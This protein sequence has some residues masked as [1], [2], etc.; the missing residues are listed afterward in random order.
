[1]TL[2]LSSLITRSLPFIVVF[3]LGILV[4][5]Q[6]SPT[7]EHVETSIDTRVDSVRVDTFY[8]ET[9]KE[10]EEITGE[11]I[12]TTPSD[13]TRTI[14]AS[15]SDPMVNIDVQ[16]KNLS[17]ARF[18]YLLKRR[19]VR[20]RS[21]NLTERITTTTTI[22][23]QA[24]RDPYLSIGLYTDFDSITPTLHY[25]LRNN[26]TVMY[27]YNPTKKYHTVGFSIP[28]SSLF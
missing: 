8:V 1:M 4:A 14:S 28:I 9:I 18:S 3:A 12:V 19:H 20:E 5:R 7:I 22:T 25:T 27:G 26:M 11:G 10:P 21:F 23:K 13:S 16:I 17:R 6:C 24:P 2:S 15:Y